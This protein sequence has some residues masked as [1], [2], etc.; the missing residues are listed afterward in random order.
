MHRL[1][2]VRLRLHGR[3]IRPEREHAQRDPAIV[4][5]QVDCT[6]ASTYGA[7]GANKCGRKRLEHMGFQS[8]V[9]TMGSFVRR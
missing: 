7:A 6:A 2:Q 4:G 9:S 1:R 3:H 5:A 8:R